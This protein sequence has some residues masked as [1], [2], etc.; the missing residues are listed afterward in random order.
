MTNKNNFFYDFDAK[1]IA[2]KLKKGANV[3]DEIKKSADKTQSYYTS[4]ADVNFT[5]P[6]SRLLKAIFGTKKR[7]KSK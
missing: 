6:E 1:G 3:D 2:D 7:R 5:T 4:S